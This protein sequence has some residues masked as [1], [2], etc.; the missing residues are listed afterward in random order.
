MLATLLEDQADVGLIKEA[1]LAEVSLL[2]GLPDLL[3]L[4][5]A[6]DQRPRLANEPVDL[7]PGH[8][9][10]ARE[11]LL[12]KAAGQLVTIGG[13]SVRTTD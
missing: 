12:A 3:A 6:A 7:V 8:V 10:Q 2:D 9:G 1:L 5:S 13:A 4:A 11:G